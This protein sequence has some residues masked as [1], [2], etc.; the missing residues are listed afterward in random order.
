MG[1]RCRRTRG[2]VRVRLRARCGI[3]RGPTVAEVAE[4]TYLVSVQHRGKYICTYIVFACAAEEL[5]LR[6]TWGHLPSYISC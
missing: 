3:G 2:H 6:E 4:A 1:I 5:G